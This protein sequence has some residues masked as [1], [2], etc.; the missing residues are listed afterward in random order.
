MYPE[1]EEYWRGVVA[2]ADETPEAKRYAEF[3]DRHALSVAP[4]TASAGQDYQVACCV[5][6]IRQVVADEIAVPRNR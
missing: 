5:T 4:V 2:G 1:H 6:G 3:A